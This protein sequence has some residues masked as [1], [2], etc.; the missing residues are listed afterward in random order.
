MN[1]RLSHSSGLHAHSHCLA[2]TTLSHSGWRTVYDLK[3]KSQNGRN[4]GPLRRSCR[5]RRV[6]PWY[7]TTPSP[8]GI[9]SALAAA[10]TAFEAFGKSGT[11]P[12]EP[13]PSC[14]RAFPKNDGCYSHV[15]RLVG[16]CSENVLAITAARTFPIVSCDCYKH[17]DFRDDGLRD[18]F[19]IQLW[20]ATLVGQA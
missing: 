5:Y 16:R 10:D 9:P 11:R 12:L 4:P 1:Q 8:H 17:A 2:P 20:C 6:W 18:H 13:L 7:S 14:V 19:H 15:L 3:A